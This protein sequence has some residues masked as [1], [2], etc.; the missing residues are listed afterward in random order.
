LAF[1]ADGRWLAA[2][3]PSARAKL[4]PLPRVDR[5]DLPKLVEPGILCNPVFN[6]AGTR[7][8]GGNAGQNLKVVPLD[9]G[10]PTRLEGFQ[11][12]TFVEAVGF[13]PSGRR[14]AAAS[15]ISY[16]EKRLR[17][18]DL[19]TGE[20]RAFELP[21]TEAT[22][23]GFTGG[24]DNVNH[25]WF[26]DEE[27]LVTVGGTHFLRWNLQNGSYEEV[28][29]VDPV[30]GRKAAASADVQKVVIIAAES[31]EEE[32][33]D[34]AELHD[35]AAGTVEELPSF[36]DCIRA[37]ALDPKGAVMVTGD[38]EGIIRV[39]RIA[40]GEPHLLVGHRGAVENVVV[41]P[42]LRW[43]AS[44][45]SDST[46][47][48]WPMPDLDQPPL[49][50]LPRDELIAKLHTLTNLRAVRDDE[51]STGWKIEVGPFPGWTTVPEW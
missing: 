25:L 39:G 29:S 34:T 42:D 26:S 30:Q 45:G 11:S 1:S 17:V 40:G 41:S 13:S 43:V 5:S 28:R 8:G 9:G 38:E 7:L 37:I 32:W 10:A 16:D 3:W 44:T 47:R 6:A 50:T 4:F 23:T 33:C 51:S 35:L 20:A 15:G 22:V 18:W 2:I 36:G 12:D 19:N 48:L 21:R 24:L 46:L 14:V 31:G 27:T 49:H